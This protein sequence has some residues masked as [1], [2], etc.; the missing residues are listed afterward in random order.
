MV[1]RPFTKL[2]EQPIE[3]SVYE[4]ACFFMGRVENKF[5]ELWIVKPGLQLRYIDDI[6][7][8]WAEGETEI[9]G[10]MKCLSIF[11]SNLKL[12]M[13]KTNFSVN[14]F[15]M[16][17]L[18]LLITNLKYIYISNPLVAISFSTL[19]LLTHCT[20]KNQLCTSTDWESKYIFY[21]HYFSKKF[22]SLVS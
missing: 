7:F 8:T 12:Q 4:Y 14:Y 18:K 9:E 5:L 1:L 11:H 2:L 19:I 10:F 15:W 13:T 3:L 16:L 22:E 6:F 17:V 21:V 20:T